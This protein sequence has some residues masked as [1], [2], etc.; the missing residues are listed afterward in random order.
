MRLG[1]YNIV[2]F[3]VLLV[4]DVERSKCSRILMV[5]VK[6]KFKVKIDRPSAFVTCGNSI[7]KKVTA[8][9]PIFKPY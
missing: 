7:Y 8:C 1:L 3:N 5:K 6:V 9:D 4:M 2:Q